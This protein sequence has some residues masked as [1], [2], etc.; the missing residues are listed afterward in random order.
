MTDTT[1]TDI[2]LPK[3]SGYSTFAQYLSAGWQ[4]AAWREGQGRF[5]V[6]LTGD[7]TFRFAAPSLALAEEALLKRLDEVA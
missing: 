5:F 1:F 7:R 2:S 3:M 6:E 4:Y